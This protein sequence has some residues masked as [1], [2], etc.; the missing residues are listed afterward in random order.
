MKFVKMHGLGNDYVVIDLFDSSNRKAFDKLSG[1]ESEL[2]SFA[3]RVCDRH[4]GI[5][6]DGILLA[7]PSKRKGYDGAMRI[8]NADGSEAEMCGNGIRC[9]AK[10][11]ADRGYSKGGKGK[12]LKIETM[13]GIKKIV[14]TDGMFRVDM[15][16]PRLLRKEIPMNG[17]AAAKAINEPLQLKYRQIKI[18]AVSMGNPHAV[19]FADDA[20]IDLDAFD[21]EEMGKEIENH[22]VFPRR[23]NV[24]FVNVLNNGEIELRAWERG[25]GETL[26]CGTGSCASLVASALN[27]RTNRKVKVHLRGGD[28][29]VEWAKDNHVYMTGPATYVFSGTVG[30]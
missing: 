9:I 2:K 20:N 13:S 3:K 4:F 18:T 7:L 6:A 12:E 10:L 30:V 21:I 14:A 26:A 24:E 17:N 8:I 15:G 23:T 11:V 27:E 22:R 29:T 5:G 19:V 16:S 28:L 25:V 1:S